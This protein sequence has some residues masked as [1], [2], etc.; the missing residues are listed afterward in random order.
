MKIKTC[1]FFN[2]NRKNF[3]IYKYKTWYLLVCKYIRVYVS[4]AKCMD[5]S[6]SMHIYNPRP[7]AQL[8]LVNV[9]AMNLISGYFPSIFVDGESFYVLYSF[10]SC[11][12]FCSFTHAHAHKIGFC[13]FVHL[14]LLN[15]LNF[16]MGILIYASVDLRR[17]C[18][19][20]LWLL[21]V[22]VCVFMVPEMEVWTLFFFPLISFFSFIFAHF[23]LF[24][25]LQIQA[26]NENKTQQ[27]KCAV[28]VSIL[29]VFVIW[30][31]ALHVQ[32]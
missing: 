20:T 24:S 3:N 21:Y 1:F 32:H 17:C 5:A 14:W 19:Q 18:M 11:W 6:I 31:N 8:G 7:P 28:A 29:C 9:C 30:I 15:K 25:S 12:C 23:S 27:T 2:H 13:D 4:S 16:N 10:L 26:E 22:C